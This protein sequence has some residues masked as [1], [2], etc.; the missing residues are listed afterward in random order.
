MVERRTSYFDTYSSVPSDRLDELIALQR[1]LI[2]GRL[3]L[4]PSACYPFDSVLRA[5]AEPSQVFPAEGQ[6]RERYLPG[7]TIADRVEEEGEELV[8]DL[9]GQPPG[10][11][12]SLQPH[13]ATQANQIVYNAV[14]KPD[15]LVLCMKTRDGGHISHNV[16]N[17]RRQPTANYGLAATGR[18]DYDQL[19]DVAVQRR[20]RLIIVGGSSLPR[21]ID[22]Q[23]CSD[24][25]REVDAAL[26]AD[27]SHTA[28][29]VAAGI[30]ESV[31]PHCDFATFSTSK[32]LRGP[33]SGVLIYRDTFAGEVRDSIF[34]KTQGGT[35]ESTVLAKFAC[36][37]EWKSR[38][39][40]SYASSVVE[41]ARRLGRGLAGHGIEL[42]SG[43]TDCHML[44]LDLRSHE[45]SGAEL[46]RELE[47]HRVLVNR[48][49]IP[50]D[51][52]SPSATSGLR[53]G[54][55]NIAILGYG[56]HDLDRLAGWLGRF[57]Q[58]GD[59]RNGTVDELIRKYQARLVTP[60]W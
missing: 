21:A 24:I 36:F 40:E 41:A 54:T 14:L 50:G 56:D 38:G 49:L 30:H 10:Y 4:V 39:I 43:G 35:I 27:I 26:L 46:E 59:A 13:S 48:N 20:P 44:L 51:P 7:A 16:V 8:L 25:A 58:R 28:T 53:L 2:G 5:L 33:T 60:V 29:F 15:D 9:F 55:A 12:A 47:S 42:V 11:R 23:V 19:R 1:G 6:P 18:V 3:H 17:S 52:R 31:F 32:N 34:P 57:L 37:T 45:Y 22:F